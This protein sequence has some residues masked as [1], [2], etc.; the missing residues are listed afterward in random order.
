MD[1]WVENIRILGS[2][3]PSLNNTQQLLTQ[4]NQYINNTALQIPDPDQDASYFYNLL[5]NN[6]L[7]PL[8]SKIGNGIFRSGIWENG[9]WNNGWRDDEQARDF[10]SVALSVLT[11]TDISWKVELRGSTYSIQGLSP[12]DKVAIGNIIAIDINDNKF[13]YRFDRWVVLWLD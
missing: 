5:L 8:F 13:R 7:Y 11:N 1:A 6:N 12:G 9:V 3:H 4:T 10:D 2:Y